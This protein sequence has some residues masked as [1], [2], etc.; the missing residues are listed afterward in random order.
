MTPLTRWAAVGSG[1]PTGS[2]SRSWFRSYGFGCSYESIADCTCSATTIR[3]RRDE[4]IRA[5]IFAE[6]K[7]IARES[8]DRII[9]L[10]LRDLAVDGCIIKAPGGREM[11]RSQT[12]RSQEARHE[13]G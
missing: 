5:G 1:S 4:W 7:K 13:N 6:L 12:G 9:G 3:G 8:Y 11:R 10:L 2:S